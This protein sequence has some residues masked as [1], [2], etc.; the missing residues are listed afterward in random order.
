M[1]TDFRGSPQLARRIPAYRM[2]YSHFGQLEQWVQQI[3][4]GGFG[5]LEPQPSSAKMSKED[6]NL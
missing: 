1:A 2:S 6:R 5:L 3:K 4:T